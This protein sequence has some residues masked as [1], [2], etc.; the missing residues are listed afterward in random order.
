MEGRKRHTR[1]RNSANAQDEFMVADVIVQ[2]ITYLPEIYKAAAT[3]DGSFK[4]EY[5]QRL[6]D[7]GVQCRNEMEKTKKE[8]YGKNYINL[9]SYLRFILQQLTNSFI[10]ATNAESGGKGIGR[11]YTDAIAMNINKNIS[12]YHISR[13]L[14]LLINDIHKQMTEGKLPSSK[15]IYKY[16]ATID[17]KLI[18]DCFKTV[19]EINYPQEA[20]YPK[21]HSLS[22]AG[23]GESEE[24]LGLIHNI[25]KSMFY[26]PAIYEATATKDKN[27]DETEWLHRLYTLCSAVLADNEGV[28]RDTQGKFARILKLV[29]DEFT[30][31]CNLAEPGEVSAVAVS[32]TSPRNES[33]RKESP[34]KDESP[35]KSESPRGIELESP[36]L[37]PRSPRAES[38]RSPRVSNLTDSPRSGT[39]TSPRVTGTS[40]RP[41]SGSLILSSR[42]PEA[43]RP[44]SGSIVDLRRSLTSAFKPGSPRSPRAES[45]RSPRFA[46]QPI[47]QTAE[48]INRDET[49]YHYP[50]LLGLILG[51]MLRLMDR[52]DMPSLRPQD[53][54]LPVYQ[55]ALMIQFPVSVEENYRSLNLTTPAPGQKKQIK[56]PRN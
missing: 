16:T 9:I 10:V 50:R 47:E 52:P 21:L 7:I 41:R 11:N 35:R 29:T 42:T 26:A 56:S 6:I 36:Q 2:H 25:V 3:K 38:P 18:D 20:I 5:M 27:K 13:L 54:V 33:P 46:Q 22:R 19:A 44:R 14:G 30:R 39:G 31:I 8:G 17:K 51:D 1:K 34:R 23:I 49:Q 40:P 53:R 24:L 15:E 4:E 43:P 28:F 37:S 48:I 45:P 32:V 12:D 55:L